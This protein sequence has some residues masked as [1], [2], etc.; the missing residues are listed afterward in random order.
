MENK[1]KIC[2]KG[3]TQI[4]PGFRS[5]KFEYFPVFYGDVFRGL[6]PKYRLKID[7]EQLL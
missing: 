6:L 7:F 1:K 3:L 2:F 4:G 5:Y